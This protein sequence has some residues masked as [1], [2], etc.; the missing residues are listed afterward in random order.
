[1]PAEILSI[2]FIEP[3]PGKD[4]PSV[5]LLRELAATLASKG[6]SRD[7]IY[8]DRQDARRIVLLRYWAGDEARARAQ[9]DPDVHRFW[10]Q[11]ALVCRVGPVYE[12]LETI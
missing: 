8:R 5:S 4:D 3:L 6:Y 10:R 12:A 9:E 2:A 7:V 11:L 1:M